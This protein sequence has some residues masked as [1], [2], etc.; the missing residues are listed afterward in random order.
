MLK[1]NILFIFETLESILSCPS[2][3]SHDRLNSLRHAIQYFKA[4]YFQLLRMSVN[5]FL[6]DIAFSWNI[7]KIFHQNVVN[8]F[9]SGPFWLC[10]R[11]YMAFPEKRFKPFCCMT[12]CVMPRKDG[13]TKPSLYRGNRK[14]T[15]V[16]HFL[17]SLKCHVTQYH[18]CLRKLFSSKI[19]LYMLHFRFS[20]ASLFDSNDFLHL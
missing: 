5:R 8:R 19:H 17:C 3:S 10:R 11:F 15:H 18:E 7:L 2:S 13:L 1:K 12:R 16:H 6:L 4:M 20:F 9:K 14:C